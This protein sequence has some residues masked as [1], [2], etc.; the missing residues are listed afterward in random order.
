M[1]LTGACFK[2]TYEGTVL[3]RIPT[4]RHTTW[5]DW[6]REYPATRVLAPEK[7]FMGRP[8]DTGYF[9]RHGSRSGGDYL[10]SYFPSTIQTRDKR[11]A[12]NAL[13]YGI[14]VGEKA[15]AYPFSRLAHSPVVEE[16]LGNV[17]VTIWFD[18][19]SRSAAAFDRTVRDKVLSFEAAG[20][21]RMRDADGGVWNMEGLCL[22]GRLKGTQLTPLRGLMAEWY[23]WFA[24][25]PGTTVWGE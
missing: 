15:R 24:N 6:R 21:G 11:L 4:G 1:H 9:D 14:V 17:D 2:G 23:G 25:Y 18:P 19:A 5:A 3:T 12:L 22:D 7:R 13:L 8:G 16:R 10:P 20:P